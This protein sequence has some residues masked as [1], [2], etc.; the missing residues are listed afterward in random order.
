MKLKCKLLG[1]DNKGGYLH[2]M[3]AMR[4]RYKRQARTKQFLFSLEVTCERCGTQSVKLK[5]LD[6]DISLRNR[7]GYKTLAGEEDD[8]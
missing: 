5:W 2:P 6:D 3:S 4:Y 1:C 8:Q 7:F